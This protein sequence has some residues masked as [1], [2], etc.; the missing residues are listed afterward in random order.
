MKIKMHKELVWTYE[1]KWHWG[2]DSS[3]RPTNLRYKKTKLGYKLYQ[4]R[5][6]NIKSD[7]W[8]TPPIGN[9]FIGYYKTSHDLR[10]MAEL[11]LTEEVNNNENK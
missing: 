9:L 10:K 11:L 6:Y 3:I 8:C 4:R 1:G 5:P 2:E 7:V